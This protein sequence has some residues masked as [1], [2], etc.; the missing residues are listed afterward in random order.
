MNQ[1]TKL[2]AEALRA[3]Q[4]KKTST[5][6]V[7]VH[8]V[9]VVVATPI[10]GALFYWYN[11]A[12]TGFAIQYWQCCILGMTLAWLARSLSGVKILLSVAFAAATVA[13]VGAWIGLW[14]LPLLSYFQ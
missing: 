3:Q 2:L 5:E 1:S 10:V 12:L 7:L 11:Y 9:G 8:I 14:H 6:G 13:Q 4:S